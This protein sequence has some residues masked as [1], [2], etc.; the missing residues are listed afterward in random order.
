MKRVFITCCIIAV[1]LLIS[2]CVPVS[3]L[4]ITVTELSNGVM[5]QNAG[6]IACLVLV[7][8]PEGE[9]QFELDVGQDKTVIGISQPIEI[10]AVKL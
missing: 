3:A 4:E 1:A 6:N 2:S 10:S 7:N 9:Q 8:S 5:I